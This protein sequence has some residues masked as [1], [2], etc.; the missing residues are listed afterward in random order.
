MHDVARSV[1]CFVSL[2]FKGSNSAH[3][4]FYLVHDIKMM[5]GQCLAVSK[6]KL[7]QQICR[8]ECGTNIASSMQC[9]LGGGN[10]AHTH[11]GNESTRTKCPALL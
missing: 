6:C 9:A 10:V 11:A 4:I 3:G 1:S 7:H 8:M 2:D 5:S